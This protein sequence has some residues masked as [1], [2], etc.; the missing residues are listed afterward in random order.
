MSINT[1]VIFSSPSGDDENKDRYNYAL[2]NIHVLLNMDAAE[3]RGVV[4]SLIGKTM[5]LVEVMTNM[6]WFI[7]VAS[8]ILVGRVN[9]PLSKGELAKLVESS[10]VCVDIYADYV[11]SMSHLF[12]KEEKNQEKFRLKTV[13][14]NILKYPLEKLYAEI[15]DSK[16]SY[17]KSL[18]DW[19]I[20][21]SLVRHSQLETMLDGSREG[22]MQEGFKENEFNTPEDEDIFPVV[23]AL[24]SLITTKGSTMLDLCNEG[25]KE[26]IKKLVSQAIKS[27]SSAE[28]YHLML[29]LEQS[30]PLPSLLE[31]AS[32]LDISLEKR[33]V[34]FG[35][36][37]IHKFSASEDSLFRI[38]NSILTNEKN[39][40]AYKRL[41]EAKVDDEDY[42]FI[43]KVNNELEG[44]LENV[45]LLLSEGKSLDNN[46]LALPPAIESD[47]DDEHIQS[48]VDNNYKLLELE[49]VEGTEEGSRKVSYALGNANPDDY[50]ENIVDELMK[51]GI[52]ASSYVPD[53]IN[54]G[55]NVRHKLIK[56]GK[57]ITTGEPL[58]DEQLDISSWEE[59]LAQER[60]KAEEE[61]ANL[62]IPE[63][64]Q[65]LDKNSEDITA[66]DLKKLER[67][68]LEEEEYVLLTSNYSTEADVKAAYRSI[69]NGIGVSKE[70][71]D[72]DGDFDAYDILRSE[73]NS[74]L[75]EIKIDSIPF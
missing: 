22:L 35:L 33:K 27:K 70:Y 9:I 4:N 30:I 56:E 57:A 19:K 7:T 67:L 39:Y 10:I 3:V 53:M 73:K 38:D 47:N 12:S 32:K 44:R 15:K 59:E 11:A 31:L 16:D 2:N 65:L 23:N 55:M 18:Q 40:R 8:D 29:T 51:T 36:K 43:S 26:I 37:G 41:A 63:V 74:R 20:L 58:N 71:L 1:P 62:I 60:Q 66:L 17:V 64:N 75:A 68:I 45:V 28:Y 13:G 52:K 69:T 54:D 61:I 49:C 24:I 46:S 5:Q 72:E 50:E 6:K 34:T 48:L 42:K 25:T 14:K 21:K